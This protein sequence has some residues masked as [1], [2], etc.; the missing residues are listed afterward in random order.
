[1]V[2]L[3]LFCAVLGGTVMVCQ[4]LM[5]LGGL[6]GS[7][8]HADAGAADAM[9]HDVPHD[10]AH[11]DAPGGEA[12]AD[13]AQGDEHGH[14]HGSSWL[15]GVLS[16]RTLV[17]AVAFFG[18]AGMAA[19]SAGWPPAS[20]VEAAVLAAVGALFLVYWLMRLMSSFNEE[21]TV[22]IQRAVGQEGTV[23]IPI[24]PAH[25]GAGKIQVRVQGRLMEY[26]AVTSTAY[27][28]PAGARARVVGVAGL[29]RLEVDP[30][31][32]PAGAA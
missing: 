3:F 5:T 19:H 28:M 9:A 16:F 32:E 11:G 27:E 15:F 31:P 12:H 17:A 8:T 10:I 24:P 29:G 6:G 22:R 4:F 21:D 23:Y 2:P 7:D 25:V 14:G 26:E 1:M 20:Q 30:V 13:Q 18:I